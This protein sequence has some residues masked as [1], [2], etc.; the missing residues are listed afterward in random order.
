MGKFSGRL[1]CTDLDDTLLTDDK[2]ISDE[3]ISAI[4]YF[5]DN[6]G[7]FTF[8]TGRMPH[9]TQMLLKYI[10]PNAPIICFNGA[11][12][13]DYQK[14]EFICVSKLN[15]SKTER[16]IDYIDK[17]F[18][19]AGIEIC[20]LDTAYFYKSNRILEIQKHFEDFPDNY[21]N[22]Y[23]SIG[24]D[25]VKVLFT[26]EENEI[27]SLKTLIA[28]SDFYND[29]SFMQSS[30]WY[31]E[32]LPKNA[33]KGDMLLKLADCLGVK[34]ENTIAFGDNENDITLVKNAGVGV[35][36]Q[37]ALESVKQAADIITVDHNSHAIA[38]IINHMDKSECC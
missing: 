14:Q 30:P 4:K 37:N 8:A 36:V 23:H 12:I 28:E 7:Y 33:T 20:S 9:G 13:Y 1:L 3:N 32:I 18:P 17:N 15:K 27:N 26:V 38:A 22:D 21:V 34:Y 31:Y 19:S 6:G 24:D 29:F 35:A 11:A 16:A 10:M 5:M 25:W 2:R